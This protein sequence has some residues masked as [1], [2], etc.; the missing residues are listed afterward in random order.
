ME[1][2]MN[3]TK[4]TVAEGG[5][6]EKKVGGGRRLGASLLH[7]TDARLLTAVGKKRKK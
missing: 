1:A 4:A 3:D 7:Q 2:R 6:R 5:G